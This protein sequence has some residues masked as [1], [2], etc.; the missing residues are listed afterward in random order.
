MSDF[1]AYRLAFGGLALEPLT[2]E[3]EEMLAAF[4]WEDSTF[5]HPDPYMAGFRSRQAASSLS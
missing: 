3:A 2:K 5:H 4:T 1:N